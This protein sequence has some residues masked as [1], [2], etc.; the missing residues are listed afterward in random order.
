MK[1]IIIILMAILLS[2][3]YAQNLKIKDVPRNV[4]DKFSSSYSKATDV[5]WTKEKSGYEASFKNGKIDM[6]VNFDEKGNVVE[7]E[8]GIK[9]SELPVEVRES[10]AKNY[11]K[12]KI[13]EAVKIEAKGM[14]TYEVEVRRS[15]GIIDLIYDEHGD[16]KSKVKKVPSKED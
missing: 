9:L 16:L 6:S 8:T 13:T 14:I 15:K 11:S 7:T 4:R 3:S 1:T 5:K 10:V 12:Y 2:T